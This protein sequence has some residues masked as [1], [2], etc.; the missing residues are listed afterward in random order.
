MLFLLFSIHLRLYSSLA[1]TYSSVWNCM[2]LNEHFRSCFLS[3]SYMSEVWGKILLT[4][5][6]NLLLI[7]YLV[8]LSRW[9]NTVLHTWAKTEFYCLEYYRLLGP[10]FLCEDPC[11]D[12]SHCLS[13]PLLPQPP[14]LTPSHWVFWNSMLLA[15]TGPF[16]HFVSRMPLRWKVLGQ[17]LNYL[18]KA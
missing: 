2:Y 13:W 9:I 3:P 4:H 16:S 18:L 17:P 6:W 11:C 7:K 12:S 14:L 5:S 8:L 1:I 10:R 15:W